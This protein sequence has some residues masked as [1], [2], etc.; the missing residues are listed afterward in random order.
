M[1]PMQLADLWSVVTGLPQ[2]DCPG[3][4]R[5][6]EHPDSYGFPRCRSHMLGVLCWHCSDPL[7]YD[8]EPEPHGRDCHSCWRER[9][10]RL[11]AQGKLHGV[12][13]ERFLA[14]TA[15]TDTLGGP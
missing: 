8:A 13:L 4:P 3:C 11:H 7:D 14:E 10:S 6:G 12:V 1:D 5:P 9:M 2:C 15:P